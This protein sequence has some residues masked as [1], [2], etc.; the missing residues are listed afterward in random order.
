MFAIDLVKWW[1]V[2][3]W[4][5]FSRGFKTTLKDTADTFSIGEL[6]RTLFKPYRQISANVDGNTPGARMNAIF[7]K[8][9]SRI[10]GMLSRLVLIFCGLI[11]ML[12]ELMVGGLVI[13][14]WPFVPA[15]PV[16][17]IVL[18]IVGVTL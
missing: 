5:V 9:I 12:I 11:V 17:G 6:L 3:G 10:V 1:Y 8:L 14:M 2:K 7:D 16:V 15:L 4:G 13:I 18:T